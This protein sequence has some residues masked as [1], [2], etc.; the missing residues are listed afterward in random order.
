MALLTSILS[1]VEVEYSRINYHRETYCS[2]HEVCIIQIITTVYSVI[3]M[4]VREDIIVVW[5]LPGM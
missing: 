4:L 2:Q 1:D 5:D 3:L